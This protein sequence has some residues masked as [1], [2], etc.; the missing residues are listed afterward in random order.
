MGPTVEEYDDEE[1]RRKFPDQTY[2]T[3]EPEP[4]MKGKGVSR[5]DLILANPT[6]AAA[7]TGHFSRWDLVLERH[8]PQEVHLD[9]ELLNSL[10]VV[11]KTKGKI[12]PKKEEEDQSEDEDNDTEATY[13]KARRIYGDNL[14]NA[15]EK[16]DIDE[17]HTIWNKMAEFSIE[18]AK[19]PP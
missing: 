7:V 11:Q 18:A 2:S 6:A 14:K 4:G 3:S 17:A 8:V 13:A 9:L 5:I 12:V 10:E 1:R 16:E 15:L 19:G